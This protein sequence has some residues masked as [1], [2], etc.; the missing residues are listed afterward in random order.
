MH[1]RICFHCGKS[2]KII[3][4][5]TNYLYQRTSRVRIADRENH[6]SSHRLYFCS[7]SCYHKD[8]LTRKASSLVR[9]SV[10]LEE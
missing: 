8:Q 2:F 6:F 1:Y 9:T 10:G 4:G 5:C 7:Y 3:C